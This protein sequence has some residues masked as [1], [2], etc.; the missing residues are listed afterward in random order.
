MITDSNNE[1]VIVHDDPCSCFF[2]D[3]DSDMEGERYTSQYIIVYHSIP[4]YIMQCKTFNSLRD[5]K[6]ENSCH[7][8]VH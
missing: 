5:I 6:D 4:Q 1:S 2:A 3:S 7:V 8:G